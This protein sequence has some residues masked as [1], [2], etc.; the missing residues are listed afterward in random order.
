MSK[1]TKRN[2]FRSPKHLQWLHEQYA[3][4]NDDKWT[5]MEDETLRQ[6]VARF[7]TSSWNLITCCVKSRSAEQCRIRW[8]V[9]QNV[10]NEIK[11]PW[12]SES[13]EQ[14][15]IL[16]NIFGAEKWP[17]ISSYVPRRNAKQCREHFRNQLD[18]S[19]EKKQWTKQEEA[20]IWE[21]QSQFGNKWS[22]MRS[23]LPGRTSNMIKNHWHSFMKVSF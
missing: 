16:V 23:R 5:V 15:S 22:M 2:D 8:R 11:G 10:G 4:S 7:G 21:M 6:C 20:L 19:I 1:L 17:V 12:D 3:E 18:P 13:D 14:L 9:F